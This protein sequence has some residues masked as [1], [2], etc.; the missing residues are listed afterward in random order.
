M[1]DSAYISIPVRQASDAATCWELLLIG[2]I[3]AT[4]LAQEPAA[5]VQAI[6]NDALAS[7]EAYRDGPTIRIM[8]EV[9]CSAGQRIA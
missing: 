7:L 1:V 8:G 9:L 2:S 6:Q 5:V 3:F 4:W